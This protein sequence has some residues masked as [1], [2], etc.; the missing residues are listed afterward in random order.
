MNTR[1]VQAALLSLGYSLTVDGVA[2]P[3]T[4]VQMFQRGKGLAADGVVGPQNQSASLGVAY[5][6]QLAQDTQDHAFKGVLAVRF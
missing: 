5:T 2:G 1:E 3:T 4:A 6:G